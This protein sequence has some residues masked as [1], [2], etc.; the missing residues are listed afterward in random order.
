MIANV[1]AKE[2]QCEWHI[3]L[4]Q[5]PNWSKLS[6]SLPFPSSQER[7]QKHSLESSRK[8]SGKQFIPMFMLYLNFVTFGFL[9]IT[10]RRMRWVCR[11]DKE[12][13]AYARVVRNCRVFHPWH[14]VCECWR[15]GIREGNEGKC[16]SGRAFARGLLVVFHVC[17]PAL[18]RDLASIVE[19]S[20]HTTGLYLRKYGTHI[21]GHLDVC[22]EGYILA[23]AA[24]SHGDEN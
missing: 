22:T 12:M 6:L 3:K 11:L 2:E 8:S 7:T 15:D 21:T 14:S 20:C 10:Q 16:E 23:R 24:R 1:T 9:Q 13:V 19:L 4:H 5:R 18:I 17:D